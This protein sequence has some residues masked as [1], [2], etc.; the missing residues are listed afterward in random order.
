MKKTQKRA[1]MAPPT[2]KLSMTGAY[3]A[4]HAVLDDR[5]PDSMMAGGPLD[6][7]SYLPS[8]SVRLSIFKGQQLCIVSRP[9]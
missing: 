4:W 2:A 1:P 7:P 3:F 6:A 9:Q 8:G 5:E